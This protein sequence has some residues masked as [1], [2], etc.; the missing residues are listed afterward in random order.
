MI[1]R[2]VRHTTLNPRRMVLLSSIVLALFLVST[3]FMARAIQKAGGSRIVEYGPDGYVTWIEPS[4][5][6]LCPGEVLE[7]PVAVGVNDAPA[8][9]IIVEQWCRQK[10]GICPAGSNPGDHDNS[11]PVLEQSSIDAVARRVVPNLAP[12]HWELRHLNVSI[13]NRTTSVTGYGVRF[14]V[15]TGCSR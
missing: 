14:T 5:D 13:S 2:Q 9:V 7:Y 4:G 12:G 10:G 6:T 11:T 15:P 1:A 8:N 3:C